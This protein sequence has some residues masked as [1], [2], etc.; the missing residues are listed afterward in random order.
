MAGLARGRTGANHC[1]LARPSM[2]RGD[3][4]PARDEDQD[5]RTQAP[6]RRADLVIAHDTGPMH[7]A[8][9][10]GARL[11]ALFGPTPPSSFVPSDDRTTVLWGGAHLACRPCYDGREFAECSDNE[12]MSSIS[13]D[14][15]LRTAITIL[16][17]NTA[18]R[19]LQT[20]ETPDETALR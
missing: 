11:V 13:A 20:T 4:T 7:L 17:E 15:V 3:E 9:L 5:Q 6:E 1:L 18:I 10:V 19:V 2:Q 14:V 12:C 8:R 16:R